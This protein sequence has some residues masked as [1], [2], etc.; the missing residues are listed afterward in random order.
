VT[1]Q[2]Q[3]LLAGDLV[4]C[5]EEPIKESPFLSFFTALPALSQVEQALCQ[6]S[7]LCKKQSHIQWHKTVL[8]MFPN[9][10]QIWKTYK[11]KL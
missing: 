5:D 9:F 3:V 11:W 6:L 10:A 4:T 8:Q 1:Y 2:H 7:L